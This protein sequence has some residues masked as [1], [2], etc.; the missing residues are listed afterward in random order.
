MSTDKFLSRRALSRRTVVKLGVQ[1][2][3]VGAM[4]GLLTACGEEEMAIL[5]ADPNSLSFSQ[6]SLRQANKYVEVSKEA[7][8]NCL[9]CAF[10][11]AEEG[12]SCGECDIFEGPANKDGYCESWSA[13]D[14][15][16]S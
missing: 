11:R 2:P 10:F 7:G 8:K 4:A 13:K 6:N 9:N 15:Q 14:V 3:A 5:C 1:V 12:A 16:Q